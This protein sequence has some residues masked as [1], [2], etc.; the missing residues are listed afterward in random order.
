VTGKFRN[1][2]FLSCRF[3]NVAFLNLGEPLADAGQRGRTA[4]GQALLD[5]VTD[6]RGPAVQVQL[7]QHV[8]HVVLDGAR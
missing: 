4:S 7:A 8:L 1:A 2:T 5:R 3:M 6:Q